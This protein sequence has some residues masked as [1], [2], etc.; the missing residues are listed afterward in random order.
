MSGQWLVKMFVFEPFLFGQ[1]ASFIFSGKKES[2]KA[3]GVRKY[4]ACEVRSL[5]FL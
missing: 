3:A 4:G 2:R 1:E 5:S